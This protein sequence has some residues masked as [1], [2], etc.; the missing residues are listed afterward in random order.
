MRG[1]GTR[2]PKSG[3]TR[4]THQSNPS[5]G[6]KRTKDGNR[7]KGTEQEKVRTVG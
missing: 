2:V 6:K 4:E 5:R 7:K 3:G 1:R